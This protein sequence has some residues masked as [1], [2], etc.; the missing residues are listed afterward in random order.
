MTSLANQSIKR[1]KGDDKNGDTCYLNRNNAV[2]CACRNGA[3]KLVGSQ[4]GSPEAE[5]IAQ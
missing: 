5:C 4:L 3:W 1:R 2:A